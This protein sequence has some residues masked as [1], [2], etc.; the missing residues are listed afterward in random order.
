VPPVLH[1]ALLGLSVAALGGAGLRA[2]SRVV[3]GGLVRVIAAATLATAA[4]VAE[5]LGLGLFG[6]GGSTAGL[7]IAALATW[8]AA[9]VWLPRPEVSVL[10]E[11]AAWWG[12]RPVAERIAFG[13][14]LGAGAAWLAWQLRH[15]ALGF[16][17]VYYHLPEVVLFVQGGEPGSVQHVTPVLPVG[18]YPLTTEVTVAW[19]AGIARS[20]VPALLVPWLAIAL[21][22]TS[23]VA[24]LRALGVTR[25]ACA[26]AALAC[27]TSPWL[28]GWQSNGS[29]TDGPALAWLLA[30]GAL[31][32]ASRER[33]GLLGPA[34]VAAGLAIGCKT[35][36]LPL[37]AVVLAATLWTLRRRLPR[38]EWLAATTL[39]AL[40]V[41]GVW[42][43]RNLVTH[44]SPFWPIVATPW[45]DPVPPLVAAADT[46][47]LDAPRATLHLIGHSYLAGVGGGVLLLA[48]AALA[49]L[50]A[51]RRPVVIA[52][53]VVVAGTLLWAASPVTGISAAHPLPANAFSTTRYALPVMA[54][55]CVA[56]ALAAT[57][58]ARGWRAL[59]AL[60]ALAA[61]A[62]IDVAQTLKI[63]F[64]VAPA[65]STPIAGALA[66][67]AL[68]V[69]MT[70][71]ARVLPRSAAGRR[72]R[73][74]RRAA[75]CIASV[76][77]GLLLAVPA[78]GLVG[79]FGATSE[80]AVA[81]AVHQLAADP[82]FRDG[83]APV[84][85]WPAYIAPLAGDSLRHRLHAIG[86]SESC[87][88]LARRGRREWVVLYANG[89]GPAVA[90]RIVRC[91]PR[92]AFVSGGVS[93]YR[94][95]EG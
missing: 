22:A 93:V 76:G 30:C 92:P 3:P 8:A 71:A 1:H 42:Y 79:R 17:A 90:H 31:C 6:L 63:G 28:L 77:A 14:V 10:S 58:A 26:L 44:G 39:T 43:V 20:F 65:A 32:A 95:A 56:L 68:A 46:S 11:L 23:M 57:L 4:A 64:P 81:G 51:P 83:T 87:A 59:V 85:T 55:A 16:D 62:V 60:L 80:L 66:G 53:G 40:A 70:L 47:F 38:W 24:G 34:I 73:L 21:S 7:V 35:T 88:E 36:V 18:N 69:A 29:L 9:A 50:I 54:S 82:S 19:A 86:A 41:G 89:Y 37:A 45:G 13:A 48:A 78:A 72:V 84:A 15:P 61:A 74:D 12:E 52:A 94:P 91:L 2:A 27:C 49:P 75:V 33:P 67:G 25:I 5:A